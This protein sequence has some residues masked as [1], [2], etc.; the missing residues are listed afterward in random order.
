MMNEKSLTCLMWEEM[1]S[2]MPFE[3]DYSSADQ[4]LEVRTKPDNDEI[5]KEYGIGK[6]L[7]SVWADPYEYHD[8]AQAMA[9]A[10]QMGFEAAQAA[11]GNNEN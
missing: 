11:R 2:E 7:L 8:I 10:Y 3:Y 6:V 5:G 4:V 1:G 9:I